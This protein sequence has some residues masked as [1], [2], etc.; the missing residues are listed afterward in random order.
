MVP[1]EDDG[2]VKLEPE[3]FIAERTKLNP[4]KR[5]VNRNSVKNLDSKQIIK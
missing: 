2:E 5:K 3:E 4:R 1:L